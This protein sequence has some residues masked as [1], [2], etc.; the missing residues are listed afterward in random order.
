MTFLNDF[1]EV[2]LNALFKL[3]CIFQDFAIS[4]YTPNLQCSTYYLP[5]MIEMRNCNDVLK[6]TTTAKAKPGSFKTFKNES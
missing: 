1:V 3:Y 6:T 2:L 5:P 4:L